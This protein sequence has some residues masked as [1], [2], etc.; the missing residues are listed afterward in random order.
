VI[1]TICLLMRTNV[2]CFTLTRFSRGTPWLVLYLYSILWRE[3]WVHQ[4]CCPWCLWLLLGIKLVVVI[5]FVIVSIARTS[6]FMVISLWI[7]LSWHFRL[8][9]YPS[10]FSGWYNAFY[11]ITLRINLITLS[12]LFSK[13][14]RIYNIIL[15]FDLWL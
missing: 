11:L 15:T 3:E 9:F 1:C 14:I 4:A 6:V 10:V 8:F 13:L 12:C 2:L 5:F 7:T